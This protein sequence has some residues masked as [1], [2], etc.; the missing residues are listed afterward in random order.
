[1]KRKMYVMLIAIGMITIFGAVPALADSSD[2]TT[3]WIVP[4]DT[5]I[6][7]SFPTGEGKVEFDAAGKNFTTLGASSQASGTAALTITN[8]GN[9]AVKIDAKWTADWPTGV[10]YV[11]ISISDWSDNTTYGTDWLSYSSSNETTNQTWIASLAD[12]GT[13]DFWFWTD[14]VDVDET[15]GVDRTLRIYSTNA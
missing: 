7:I 3:T 9:T 4:A 14:G 11:N 2:V 15:A 1:M 8:N 12:D 10:N 13:E 5:T 6:A